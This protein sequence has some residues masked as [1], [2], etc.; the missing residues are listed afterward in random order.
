[1]RGGLGSFCA[2]PQGEDAVRLFVAGRDT[3]MRS[4][5]GVVT[6]QWL[7]QPRVVAISPQPVLDL[8]D[9][10]A[11]DMDGVSYPWMVEN[12]TELWMY[13]VGWN[14][15]GGEILTRR[16]NR[17]SELNVYVISSIC[18]TLGI[19][20]RLINSRSLGLTGRKT[21]RLIQ[22]CQACDAT[23]YLSCT[24]ARRYIEPGKFA[25]IG[26]EIDYMV[27]D[28]PPYPQQFGPFVEGAS[29]VDLLSNCGSTS[30]EFIVGDCDLANIGQLHAGCT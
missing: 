5:I 30:I 28:Y 21:D 17:L 26:V 20:T 14:R 9:L 8:G 13:Y 4:R 1:M 19:R 2:M 24:S 23:R 10:G 22:I 12:G 7:E 11:F 6:R 29:I 18:G 27:Y 3:T 25:A 15:L 16:R